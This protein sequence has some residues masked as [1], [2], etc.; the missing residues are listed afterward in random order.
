MPEGFKVGVDPGT[1]F[2]PYYGLSIIGG[3]E[4]TDS[5]YSRQIWLTVDGHNWILQTDTTDLLPRS[6]QRLIGAGNDFFSIGGT[7]IQR[8][9]EGGQEV[10]DLTDQV[11]T[12]PNGVSWELF[13]SHAPFGKRYYPAVAWFKDKVWCIGGLSTPTES[14]LADVW[15]MSP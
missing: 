3:G 6:G 15:M 1:V 2:N 9:A 4:P 12:S 5:L 10:H 7:W 8:L 13:D 14:P 11:W